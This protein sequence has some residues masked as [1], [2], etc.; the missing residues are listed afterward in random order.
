MLDLA[1]DWLFQVVSRGQASGPQGVLLALKKADAD[2][3]LKQTFT[4]TD[5]H[6]VFEKILPGDYVIEAS[7]SPWIFDVVCLTYLLCIVYANIFCFHVLFVQ[8]CI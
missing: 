8:K 6:Y 5:G 1:G 3:V 7:R 4:T 2:H